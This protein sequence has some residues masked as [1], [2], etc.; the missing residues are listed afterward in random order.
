MGL[1]DYRESIPVK[2]GPVSMPYFE[3]K[4]KEFGD[5]LMNSDF[6]HFVNVIAYWHDDFYRFF[7]FETF[8]RTEFNAYRGWKRNQP[9]DDKDKDDH[10]CCLTDSWDRLPSEPCIKYLR[11]KCSHFMMEIENN[12]SLYPLR[13]AAQMFLGF[14][15]QFDK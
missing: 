6:A 13:S 12:V 8:R 15:A 9:G 1:N 7:L 2:I 11:L 3:K 5:L 14:L 10:V 4:L